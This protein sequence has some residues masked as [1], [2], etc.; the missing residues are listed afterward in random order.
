MFILLLSRLSERI[1]SLFCTCGTSGFLTKASGHNYK[2][3]ATG[4]G[5]NHKMS[6]IEVIHNSNSNSLTFQ[7]EALFTRIPFNLHSQAP[8][9]LVHCL[10]TS[11]DRH[12]ESC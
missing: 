3:A 4:N 8:P 12:Q 6:G 2:M 1:S 7:V 5:A 11:L 10:V 9:S